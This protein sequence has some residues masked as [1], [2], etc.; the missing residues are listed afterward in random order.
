MTYDDCLLEREAWLGGGA[1]GGGAGERGGGTRRRG[2]IYGA[3][4]P[5]V[6]PCGVGSPL[7][8]PT[9]VAVGSP[10]LLWFPVVWVPPC[11][12]PLWLRSAAPPSMAIAGW[13]SGVRLLNQGLQHAMRS[14]TVDRTSR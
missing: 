10:L 7:P 3:A 11:P 4:L 12:S 5:P 6:V 8:L 1:M 2:T 14:T 9:V 13:A